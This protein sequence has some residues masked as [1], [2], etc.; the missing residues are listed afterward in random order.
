MQKKKNG[1]FKLLKFQ[2]YIEV[3]IL[4]YVII[5]IIYITYVFIIYICLTTKT[6]IFGK[7]FFLF[8][9]ASLVYSKLL[10]FM[11]IH[12]IYNN[13]II[14]VHQLSPVYR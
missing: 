8:I 4:L 1:L 6:R 9:G 13:L 2:I 12:L 3:Y 7:F 11:H 14:Q 5:C 10:A